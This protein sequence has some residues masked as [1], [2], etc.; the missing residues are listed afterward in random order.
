MRSFASGGRKFVALVAGQL[1]QPRAE[2]HDRGGHGVGE[3]GVAAVVDEHV[4]RPQIAMGYAGLVDEPGDG[5]Q[6]GH[7]LGQRDSARDLALERGR[8]A[9]H[10]QAG[11]A[12]GG[13]HD[14]VEAG[15]PRVVL[16]VQLGDLGRRGAARGEHPVG[17]GRVG[18]DVARIEGDLAHAVTA[19]AVAHQPRRPPQPAPEHLT[20]G[21]RTAAF[22]GDDVACP[23]A[24]TTLDA[25]S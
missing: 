16:G 9:R 3:H 12:G 15:Q 24:R 19:C 10:H 13:L 2:R 21:E 1:R 17:N 22:G 7:T 6:Q 8:V 5:E 20:D 23:H 18:G 4:G 25:K 14:R 11:H